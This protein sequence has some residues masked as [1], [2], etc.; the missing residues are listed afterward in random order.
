M[1]EVETEQKRGRRSSTTKPHHVWIALFS[2][3]P[4]PSGK[5]TIAGIWLQICG[6]ERAATIVRPPSYGGG[7]RTHPDDQ[8]STPPDRRNSAAVARSGPCGSLYRKL[9]DGP[10]AQTFVRHNHVASRA[11]RCPSAADDREP[12]WSGLSAPHRCPSPPDRDVVRLLQRAVPVLR[13]L[14]NVV[15]PR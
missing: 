12:L 10:P 2:S 6:S 7:F 13:F 4:P 3:Q 9:A 15:H 5:S 1:L 8:N 11:A 14:E